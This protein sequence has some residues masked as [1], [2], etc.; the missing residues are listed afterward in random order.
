MHSLILLRIHTD[1]DCSQPSDARSRFR[2]RRRC[3]SVAGAHAP[4][5]AAVD[6]CS[7]DVALP[8]M[9]WPSLLRDIAAGDGGVSTQQ[10]S[11]SGSAAACVSVSL[12]RGVE[13]CSLIK[14]CCEP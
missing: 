12:G 7:F 1:N 3:C 8:H 13:V 11:A 5:P 6:W 2:K 9:N 10:P 14:R 4:L